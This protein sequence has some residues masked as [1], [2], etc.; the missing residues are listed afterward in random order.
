MSFIPVMERFS[1]IP[2]VFSLTWSFR[3]YSDMMIWWSRN[4]SYCYQCWI[5]LL[6]RFFSIL[7]WI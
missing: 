1:I 2:P 6:N 3:N 7:W 4:M 5:Q